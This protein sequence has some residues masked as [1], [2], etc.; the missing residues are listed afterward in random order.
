LVKDLDK[1]DLEFYDF[2]K[3]SILTDIGDSSDKK[4]VSEH[5]V[6]EKIPKI[7]LDRNLS[8]PVNVR[9]RVN[10]LEIRLQ[11]FEKNISLINRNLNDLRDDCNKK[12][13]KIENRE[14]I[15]PEVRSELSSLKSL[16]EK[17]MNVS[18]ELKTKMPVFL[19]ELE[20]KVNNIDK[21]MKDVE[22]SYSDEPIIIE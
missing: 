16:I 21:K 7:Q 9:E 5:K 13:E 19:R 18:E 22:N 2:T 10:W 3:S 11:D 14:S 4:N 20:G 8:N 1:L 6:V 12:I 17:N 15:T